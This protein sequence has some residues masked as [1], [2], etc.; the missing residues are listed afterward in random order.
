MT[1]KEGLALPHNRSSEDEARANELW[2]Q[3]GLSY[4]IFVAYFGRLRACSV[5]TESTLWLS[6]QKS[7]E[8]RIFTRDARW[9]TCIILSPFQC[10]GYSTISCHNDY[11]E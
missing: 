3:V 8:G 4:V 6:K 11:L 5:N 7:Q 10:R 9:I 2:E 1:G